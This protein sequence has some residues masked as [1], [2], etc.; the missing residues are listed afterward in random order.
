M[1]IGAYFRRVDGLPISEPLVHSLSCPNCDFQ[2]QSL[3]PQSLPGGLS[4]HVRVKHPIE[5]L[6]ATTWLQNALSPVRRSLFD[7]VPPLE[8]IPEAPDDAMDLDEPAALDDAHHDG[9]KL[10]HSYSIKQKVKFLLEM[11]NVEA[12]IK[13]R[14]GPGAVYFAISLLEEVNKMTGVPI[15]TLK[16]WVGLKE[17]LFAKHLQIRLR[18]VRKHGSGRPAVFPA[19]EALVASMIHDRRRLCRLVSKAFVLKQLKIEAEKENPVEFEKCKFS[20]GMMI[21]FFRRNRFSLRYPSCTRLNSLDEA[22]LI[23][24]AFHRDLLRVLA[25]DGDVRYAKKALDPSFG[26]FKLKY[27]FNGDEVPYRFGRVKS[28]VSETNESLTHVAWPPGWEARLATIYLVMDALGHVV[29]VVLIFAGSLEK[30]SKRQ[31][32]EVAGYK[33]KYPNV[34]VLFQ[35]KAWMNGVLLSLIT[36][37]IFLPYLRDMWAADQVDFA[38][39]LL[40]LDNG[41]GRNNSDVLQGLG[42]GHTFLMKLPPNQTG[43]VQ[44]IDDNVGRIFRDLACDHIESEVESMTSDSLAALNAAAKREMMVMAASKATA[45]WMGS[46]RLKLISARAALRTGLAMRI[47]NNCE[48]ARPARFPHGYEATIP[49]A[50]GKPVRSYFTLSP[51][52][53]PTV[54]VDVA[55]SIPVELHVPP[56]AS[57]RINILP[58]QASS[59]AIR[60]ESTPAARIDEEVALFDGWPSDEEERVFLGDEAEESSSDED[61]EEDARR[62]PRRKRWCLDGCDCERPFGS[63]KCCCERLGDRY[64]GKNCLCDSARCRAQRP[65]ETED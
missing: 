52:P 7:Y 51:V 27:R 54:V 41:P 38:E 36:K 35:P 31:L 50:S 1:S 3:S 60:V 53:P 62:N 63:R 65:H 4:L 26:R 18:K 24:R 47:D 29:A 2:C 13:A 5:F 23:C 20:S 34:H 55:I 6:E 32:A 10:R 40:V 25:D 8:P 11:D 57:V 42:D 17:V 9:K 19:A 48:G 43:H 44:M 59:V 21:N 45:E 14:M 16:K 56:P 22:I 37:K 49:A 61:D 33:R 30:P 64:C 46:E 12:E 39:S 15:P 58:A 28:I